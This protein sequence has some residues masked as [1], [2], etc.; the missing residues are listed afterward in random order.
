VKITISGETFDFDEERRPLS[1]AL[2]IEKAWGRRYAEWES[3]L[4]AGSAEATAVFVWTV[5]RRD[6]RDVTLESI[7]NGQV[8][9]DYAEVMASLA[10]AG[11]ERAK[12]AEAAAQDPTSG[13]SPLTDPD[14]TA[15]TSA[16]T[17]ERSPRSSASARGKSS[18]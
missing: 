10:A 14:G 8:D 5:W 15:T 6:G 2:A 1:E 12:A 9:F 3:E 17:S 13:A 16:A 4:M 18:G 7:L 11:A